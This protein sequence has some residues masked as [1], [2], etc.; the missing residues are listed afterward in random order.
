[1]IYFYI[2]IFAFIGA[3]LRFIFNSIFGAEFFNFSPIPLGTLVVNVVGSFFLGYI[4]THQIFSQTLNLAIMVG[5]LG[6]LTTF[7]GYA[8]D[9]LRLF[10]A[11][12]IL[13]ALVNVGLNNVLSIGFCYLGLRLAQ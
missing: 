6:A 12:Q 4:A 3:S 9:T 11:G 13:P 10:Q 7:S 8:I 1:M 5:L 2:L